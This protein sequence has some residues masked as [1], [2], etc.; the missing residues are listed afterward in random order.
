MLED[1]KDYCDKRTPERMLEL[2]SAKEK[3]I[4][5][6]IARLNEIQSV[7]RLYSNLVKETK[8]DDIHNIVIKELPEKEIFVG[9]LLDTITAKNYN[10]ANI[11]FYKFSL[12]HGLDL[13]YPFGV[14]VSKDTLLKNDY[15]NILQCFFSVPYK[16]NDIR[17]AGHYLI[18]HMFGAYG[19]SAPLFEKLLNYIK[20]NNLIICGNAYEEYPLNEM[21]TV[22]DEEFLIRVMIRIKY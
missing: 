20:E 9:P 7:M 8:E 12:Q 21:T 13:I 10:D 3:D 19:Q 22:N 17:P 2:F 16:G 18:G 14:I 4:E 5:K 1:I 6:E 11:E 15:S